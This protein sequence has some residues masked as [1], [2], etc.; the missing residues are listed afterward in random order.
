M[1]RKSALW[2]YIASKGSKCSGLGFRADSL[3]FR[4]DLG[5]RI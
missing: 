2:A 3:G 4:V 5:F 1:D